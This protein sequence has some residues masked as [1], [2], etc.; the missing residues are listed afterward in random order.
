MIY[1]DNNIRFKV[2]N[3][4]K[5]HKSKEIKSTLIEIIEAKSKY[6]IICCIYK[7][8]KVCISEFTNDFINPQ[9]EKLATENKEIILM[10]DYNIN[11]QNCNSDNETSD[12]IDTM[13]A[14][15][16]YPTINI[17]N[18]ITATSKILIHNIL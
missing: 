2:R 14:S 6:K 4:L 1:I 10:D 3:H 7:H 13:Y 9:P 12:F 17:Q 18:R 16:F 15:S 11:I 8:L 5:I